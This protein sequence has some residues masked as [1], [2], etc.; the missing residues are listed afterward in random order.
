[1]PCGFFVDKNLPFED[2]SARAHI[3]RYD[4]GILNQSLGAAEASVCFPARRAGNTQK[5]PCGLK[6]PLSFKE[7]QFMRHVYIRGMLG[8]IWLAVAVK[9][10]LSANL[11]MAPLYAVLGAAFLYSAYAAWKKDHK[12]G[13][14]K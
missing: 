9:S 13:Q 5:Y 7:V 10:V 2:I 12:G 6:I 4:I 11:E 8:L 14:M 1:M 3:L